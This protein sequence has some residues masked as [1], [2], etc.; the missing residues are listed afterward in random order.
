MIPTITIRT[1]CFLVF[2]R[3]ERRNYREAK[4][5]ADRTW[6]VNKFYVLKNVN[7]DTVVPVIN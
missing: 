6:N 2:L 1:Q 4:Y 5:E 3:N 7:K